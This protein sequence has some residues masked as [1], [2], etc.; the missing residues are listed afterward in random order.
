MVEVNSSTFS[1]VLHFTTDADLKTIIMVRNET[2]V[3]I[4][5]RVALDLL[6]IET[7]K[8]TPNGFYERN[9]MNC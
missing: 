3:L 5:V 7:I 8:L 1:Y 9:Q 2:F 6:F 4:M